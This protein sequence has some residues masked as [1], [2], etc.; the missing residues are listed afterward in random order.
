MAPLRLVGDVSYPR[1]PHVRPTAAG[2]ILEVPPLVADRF[3]QVMPLGW[4]WGLR[5]SS[6]RRVLQAVEAENHQGRPAVFTL[7]PWEI[8]TNPPRVRLPM[9]MSLRAL[10]S[11]RRVRGATSRGTSERHRTWTDR[12]GDRT[13]RSAVTGSV[14]PRAW[15]RCLACLLAV[16]QPSP[17]AA[18]QPP[19]SRP[20]ARLAIEDAPA[21]AAIRLLDAAGTLPFPVTVRVRSLPAEPAAALDARLAAWERRTIPIW[22]SIPAP[23]TTDA[24]DEWRAGLRSLFDR[25]R[26]RIDR[27]RDRHRSAACG[28]CEVCDPDRGD[29]TP[30]QRRH[31]TRRHRGQRD[32]RP[33]APDVDLR[34]GSRP[35]R[36]SS[37]RAR[38]SRRRDCRMAAAR[39]TTQA[40]LALVAASSDPSPDALITGTLEDLGSDIAI[41]AWR[42]A[43]ISASDLSRTGTVDAVAHPS[44]LRRS[45]TRARASR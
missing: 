24:I 20:L 34:R 40:G 31:G 43:G 41:R 38:R 27:S 10:L 2:R 3:G 15:W 18:Q 37:G 30:G 7:H 36:R 33:V 4:G 32:D 23:A 39:W 8:D 28:S 13:W 25:R 5:M 16:F 14:E 45:T 22:L 19:A 11:A 1:Y 29:R 9:R 21:D 42:P 26:R 12:T 6:P 35:V 44:D 17:L